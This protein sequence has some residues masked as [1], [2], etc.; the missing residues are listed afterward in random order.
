M[1]VDG[2][3]ALASLFLKVLASKNEASGPQRR[4]GV[5]KGELEEMVVVVKAGRMD[6]SGKGSVGYHS[7]ALSVKESLGRDLPLPRMIFCS[8][9]CCL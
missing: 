9:F 1:E 8:S 6:T 5:V 4:A 3:W 7:V 2:G